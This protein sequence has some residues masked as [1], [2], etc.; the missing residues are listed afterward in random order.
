MPQTGDKGQLLAVHADGS[1][2][3]D[4]SG[5]A[6]LHVLD[7]DRLPRRTQDHMHS[8]IQDQIRRALQAYL[9]QAGEQEVAALFSESTSVPASDPHARIRMSPRR[10]PVALPW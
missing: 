10:P 9:D 4:L 2:D 1:N 6:R 8:D 5:D 3:L 7:A